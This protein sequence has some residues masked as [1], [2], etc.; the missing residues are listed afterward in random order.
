M[1]LVM[2]PKYKDYL[3]RQ[4]SPETE[5]LQVVGGFVDN[6]ELERECTDRIQDARV[7]STDTE[8]LGRLTDLRTSLDM[9]RLAYIVKL[10][11]ILFKY[12]AHLK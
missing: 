9:R 7:H 6:S 1:N 3:D 2:P 5:N 10:I 8:E 12:H 11:D 4:T